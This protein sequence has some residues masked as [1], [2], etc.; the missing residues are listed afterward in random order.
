MINRSDPRIAAAMFAA[1]ERIRAVHK[2][3]PERVRR[4]SAILRRFEF[5]LRAHGADPEEIMA[6]QQTD[7][8]RDEVYTDPLFQSKDLTPS[9]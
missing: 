9:A 5:Q 1:E 6:R 3:V 4:V 8:M 2:E 7:L